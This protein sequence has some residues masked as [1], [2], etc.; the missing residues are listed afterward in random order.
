MMTRQSPILPTNPLMS[1]R[2]TKT[3]MSIRMSN[4]HQSLQ[5]D[6]RA[7]IGRS[8]SCAASPASA[9]RRMPGSPV[10]SPRCAAGWTRSA[11]SPQ[12]PLR[13][14]LSAPSA[15]PSC[16]P[17]SGR[18]R[19]S[20][21][22]SSATS[23]S[24]RRSR[25]SCSTRVI[26]QPMTHAPRSSL[27][28]ERS[29]LRLSA[30]AARSTSATA[31]RSHAWTSR[32]TLSDKKSC[33]SRARASQLRALVVSS[34]RPGRQTVVATSRARVVSVVALATHIPI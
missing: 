2:T 16:R 8:A 10:R 29:P 34:S 15:S 22:A 7:A 9:P 20:M 6:S 30:C 4:P 31:P 18:W 23:G 27:C 32:P 11:A 5:R 3:P 14:L 19:W 26:G 1:P 25:R 17:R 13:H 33:S 24:R 28:S 21:R 12:L